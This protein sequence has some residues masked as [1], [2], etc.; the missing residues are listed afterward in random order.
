MNKTA[1]RIVGGVLVLLGIGVAVGMVTRPTM[2]IRV[3]E[4][5][6]QQRAD[7]KLPLSGTRL[8]VDW[9]VA[10]AAIDLLEDGRVRVTSKV[11]L[12]VGPMDIDAIPTAVGRVVYDAGVVRVADLEI[13]QWNATSDEAGT[14]S[15]FAGLVKAIT[16]DSWEDKAKD[17]AGDAI[18]KVL[19]VVP[20]YL[21]KTD[22]AGMW[23]AKQAISKVSF[24]ADAVVVSVDPFGLLLRLIV[25]GAAFVLVVLGSVAFVFAALRGGVAGGAAIAAISIL[26]P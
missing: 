17:A 8:G 25:Y 14:P 2:D 20:V 24:E 11:H 4:L 9:S 21:L 5:E 7:A 23:L 10:S 15:K 12:D 16:P 6:V 1:W 22:T 19:D 18:Q 3:P 26:G 13:E